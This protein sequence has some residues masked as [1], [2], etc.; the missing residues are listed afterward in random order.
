T[1]YAY[2]TGTPGTAISTD[3]YTY[4]NSSWK[5]QLTSYNGTAITYDSMG[6]PLSYRGMTLTWEGKRLKTS[7][8]TTYLYDSDGQRISKTTGSTVT[9]YHY[10]GTVLIAMERGSDRLLFSYDSFG[11]PVCVNYNGTYYYYVKNAQ[12]DIIKMIDGSGSTKVTY[13]YDTWGKKISVTGT[14][15]G[16]LGILNPYRYR[17]YIYDEETGFY[18]L[19][20][21][22]Y[23]PE[24]GRFI[25]SD[26]M[27]ST[28]Q[29]VT[30]HNSYAYCLNDPIIYIDKT[31]ENAYILYDSSFP[32]HIGA[33]VQDNEGEWWHFYWGTEGTINRVVCAFG[34]DVKPKTWCKQYK[35]KVDIDAINETGDFSGTYDDMIFLEGDFSDVPHKFSTIDEP[36]NLYTNN[37]SQ[38]TT[39]ILSESK[40]KYANVLKRVSK[41]V[42]PY[43]AHKVLSMIIHRSITVGRLNKNISIYAY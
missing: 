3:T 32:T 20:S 35:G 11:S 17:G 24:T 31:G 4:G 39:R 12:G 22:Y 26:V 33:L 41:M 43:S 23:D 19:N 5:D 28:G 15:S 13:V 27:L 6:N 40:T 34:Y 8:S 18:Y 21:R 25:S 42:I 29:G 9:K 38:V 37:C 30:G 14:L 2:T 7:G 10:N 36:Y 1:T 16:T